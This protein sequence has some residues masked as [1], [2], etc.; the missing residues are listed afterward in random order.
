MV[1]SCIR[2]RALSFS[3][4]ICEISYYRIYYGIPCTGTLVWLVIPEIYSRFCRSPA[5]ICSLP[6]KNGGPHRSYSLFLQVL[7][8]KMGVPKGFELDSPSNVDVLR[9]YQT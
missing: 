5:F 1:L 7:V 8:E 9:M 2:K 6:K 4:N 3:F